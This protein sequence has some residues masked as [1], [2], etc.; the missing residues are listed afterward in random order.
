MVGAVDLKG[1]HV[2]APGDVEEAF[3]VDLGCRL[4]IFP[5]ASGHVIDVHSGGTIAVEVHVLCGAD[6]GEGGGEGLTLGGTEVAVHF[7]CHVVAIDGAVS[8]CRAVLAVADAHTFVGVD[9]ELSTGSGVEAPPDAILH[10][11]VDADDGFAHVVQLVGSGHLAVCLDGGE[12][13]GIVVESACQ[14]VGVAFIEVCFEVVVPRQ[15][16]VVVQGIAA[17][18]ADVVEI[19]VSLQQLGN[20]Q[21]VRHCLR[22]VGGLLPHVVGLVEG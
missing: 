15:R 4:V 1:C 17:T 10:A 12:E 22:F 7:A 5:L 18:D 8:P 2:I 11:V 3:G 14:L 9:A 13:V 16:P 19:G 6:E 20:G 21:E